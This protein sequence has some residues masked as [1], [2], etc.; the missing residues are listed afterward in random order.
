M[1]MAQ[2]ELDAVQKCDFSAIDKFYE[3]NLSSIVKLDSPSLSLKT[4]STKSSKSKVN[5]CGDDS[6]ESTCPSDSEEEFELNAVRLKDQ[7]LKYHQNDSSQT[8]SK[9]DGNHLIVNHSVADKN[10]ASETNIDTIAIQNSTDIQFGN[11]TFYNG[12]VFIKQFIKDENKRWIS[13]KSIEQKVQN[14][15]G[16]EN[17][18]FDGENSYENICAF[19]LIGHDLWCDVC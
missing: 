13:P 15:S 10:V 18:G 14:E 7:F 1:M 19:C 8:I 11:K 6:G 16:V 4:C 9:P 3:S 17:K 2:I 5:R 12:P